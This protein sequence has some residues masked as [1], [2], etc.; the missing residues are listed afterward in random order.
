MKVYFGSVISLG[1]DGELIKLFSIQLSCPA[2]IFLLW[3]FGCT[4]LLFEMLQLLFKKNILMKNN[5]FLNFL[6]NFL[7][8]L[9]LPPHCIERSWIQV[10]LVSNCVDLTNEMC[11]PS[12]RCVAEQSMQINIPYVIDDQVGFL[13]PQSKQH[14]NWN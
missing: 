9:A 12:E 2:V 11:T 4:I 14:L 5:Y 3:V 7:T 10:Q 13:A 6:I 1:L 8:A